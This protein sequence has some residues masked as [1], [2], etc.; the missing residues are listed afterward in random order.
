MDCT[1][2]GVGPAGTLHV[3]SDGI[4]DTRCILNQESLDLR[5]VGGTPLVAKAGD[6]FPNLEQ[7]WDQLAPPGY[8]G[9]LNRLRAQGLSGE[10]ISTRVQAVLRAYREFYE[11][12]DPLRNTEDLFAVV[13]GWGYSVYED[14]WAAFPGSEPLLFTV[15]D[16][17]P[18]L[19]I[20]VTSQRDVIA[21]TIIT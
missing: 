18:W 2:A 19:S 14:E 12:H 20:R 15:K 7:D 9:W 11:S 4:R 5:S 1:R 8:L 21:K 17:E 6:T 16:A 10:A 3:F 13:G